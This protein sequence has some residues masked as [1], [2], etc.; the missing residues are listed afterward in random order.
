L[1]LLLLLPPPPPPPP[2]PLLLLLL[3]LLALLLPIVMKLNFGC[4]FTSR[5]IV[6]LIKN[7]F[8]LHCLRGIFQNPL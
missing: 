3:L 5:S 8:A 4:L 2:P 7:A 6:L 1:L